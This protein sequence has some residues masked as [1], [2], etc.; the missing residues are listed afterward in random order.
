MKF[1]EHY[2]INDTYEVK[3]RLGKLI[4]YLQDIYDNDLARFYGPNKSKDSGTKA[5]SRLRFLP[6]EIEKIRALIL[7]QRK[8]YEADYEDK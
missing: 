8:D 1:D 4:S 7:M 2:N 5:R 6:R 3:R